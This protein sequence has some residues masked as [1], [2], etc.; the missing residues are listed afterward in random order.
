M[1]LKNNIEKLLQ[2]Q[3]A[4]FELIEHDTV[5]HS[6]KDGAKHFGIDIGQTAATLI[7][8]ADDRLYAVIVS[9][10]SGKL[11]FDTL[12]ELLSAKCVTMASRER[13][14]DE[15]GMTVG[16][17]A[18]VNLPIPCIID[19]TL[20]QYDYVYGGTGDKHLT[21]KLSP[22]SLLALHENRMVCKISDM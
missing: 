17:V 6:A 20:L 8:S 1:S 16:A 19:E 5:I 18:M 2:S 13:I 4:N 12:G 10:K 3:N 9:G 15:L 14:W 21:L 11:N 7:V 22:K